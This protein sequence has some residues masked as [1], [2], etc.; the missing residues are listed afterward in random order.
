MGG[1]VAIL[2]HRGENGERLKSQ[3]GKAEVT[4]R[5]DTLTN[6]GT[7]STKTTRRRESRLRSR[8]SRA[9]ESWRVRDFPPAL[10]LR[11]PPAAGA[12]APGMRLAIRISPFRHRW[13]RSSVCES[14]R[15]AHEQLLFARRSSLE[16]LTLFE[17][18]P[19]SLLKVVF[20]RTLPTRSPAR[21]PARTWARSSPRRIPAGR[22]RRPPW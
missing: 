6:G 4:E 12:R 20:A 2:D 22:A 5:T 18:L 16:I 17:I 1:T 7:E 10:S 19:S 14:S 11:R 9:I 13:L 8:C 21:T 3:R 15:H